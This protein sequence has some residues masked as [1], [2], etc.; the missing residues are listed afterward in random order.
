MS[1]VSSS[2]HSAAHVLRTPQGDATELSL[3]LFL[4]NVLPPLADGVVP[5][6]LVD[7]LMSPHSKSSSQKAITSKGRWR[8]F[9]QDPA[10]AWQHE[11]ES[12]RHLKGVVNSILK[13]GERPSPVTF[14]QT[15][16][17]IS[18]SRGRRDEYLPDAFL[19]GQQ[20]LHWSNIVTFGELRRHDSEEDVQEV[21]AIVIT[22]EL[23]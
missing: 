23:S 20:G 9:A 17:G 12:F 22:L 21:R 16:S 19:L 3:A 15:P 2:A 4:D 5:A 10:D 14:Y 8:G 18:S 11:Q 1:H 6:Q 13:V 7:K